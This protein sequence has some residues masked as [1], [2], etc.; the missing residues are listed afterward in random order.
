M[1]GRAVVVGLFII[2]SILADGLWVGSAAGQE[3]TDTRP[4]TLL[5]LE[6]VQAALEKHYPSGLLERRISGKPVVRMTVREDGRVRK[7]ALETTSGHPFFDEAALKVAKLARYAPGLRAGRPS[8]YDVHLPLHFRVRLP[9][10][11]DNLQECRGH[12]PRLKN[13]E[14]IQRLLKRAVTS[15]RLPWVTEATTLVAISL[16][17]TGVV[18][19]VE[20]EESSGHAGVDQVA[21]VVASFT[22]WEPGEEEGRPVAVLVRQ[23]FNFT[24]R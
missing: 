1:K 18:W 3:A 21:L 19:N 5:N 16:D 13:G 10:E 11:L 8:E 6:E 14:E 17:S 4:P 22:E 24:F 12:P 7:V 15:R 2:L 9:A 23:P 20:L